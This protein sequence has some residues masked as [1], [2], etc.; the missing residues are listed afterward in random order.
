[1]LSII[2]PLAPLGTSME[3]QTLHQPICIPYEHPPPCN[4][5]QARLGI[6]LIIQMSFSIRYA[7]GTILSMLLMLANLLLILSFPVL[8]SKKP[9]NQEVKEVSGNYITLGST[10]IRL[11][12]RQSHSRSM[13]LIVCIFPQRTH[14]ATHCAECQV[15]RLSWALDLPDAM[16]TF[17]R[18]VL[19][20]QLPVQRSKL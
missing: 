19:V 8:Q 5:W 18:D 6:M 14:S 3:I 16:G 15:P 2:L 12:P 7:P 20:S 9:R 17:C 4:C 11:R 10:A 13:S 1:M